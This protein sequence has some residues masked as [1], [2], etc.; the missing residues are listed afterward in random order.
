MVFQS[1]F[2]RACS[3]SSGLWVLGP[4]LWTPAVPWRG[5]T[6]R[7][8]TVWRSHQLEAMEPGSTSGASQWPCSSPGSI[9]P[10]TSLEGPRQQADWLQRPRENLQRSP[11]LENQNTSAPQHC[12]L[13]RPWALRSSSH[14]LRRGGHSGRRGP[15]IHST[16][17][18]SATAT[19][20]PPGLDPR[21]A[22][23]RLTQFMPGFIDIDQNSRPAPRTREHQ[24]AS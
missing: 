5:G 9:E 24:R 8:R 3:G 19:P 13:G 16:L 1:R 20:C 18:P 14:P 2:L 21:L 12:M 7:P 10:S 23:H 15:S 4:H 6:H 22:S 11:E 17:T